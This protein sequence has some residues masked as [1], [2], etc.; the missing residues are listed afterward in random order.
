MDERPDPVKADPAGAA[1][2]AARPVAD[3]REARL[4]AALRENLR[5]R[6]RGASSPG[7][8]PLAEG[9]RED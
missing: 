1:S 4:A 2:G 7:P 3:P 8:A 6:K 9:L 5:R